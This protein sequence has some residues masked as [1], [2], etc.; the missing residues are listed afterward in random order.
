MI[1]TES[2]D[3]TEEV[4]LRQ[5]GGFHENVSSSLNNEL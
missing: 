1:V 4:N 5:K 3:A 2:F